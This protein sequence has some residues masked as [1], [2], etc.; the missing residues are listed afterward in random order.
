MTKNDNAFL[1]LAFIS[2]SL[3]LLLLLL[4]SLERRWLCHVSLLY[5]EVQAP[6]WLQG[7]RQPCLV[8][9]DHCDYRS[10]LCFPMC[11]LWLLRS[12]HFSII[13]TAWPPAHPL[14]HPKGQGACFESISPCCVFKLSGWTSITTMVNISFFLILCVLHREPTGRI[15]DV[16]I[17]EVE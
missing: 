15:F 13:K 10:G 1:G 9:A 4:V 14:T 2:Y 7:S 8:R 17:F 12:A 5:V 16:L 11:V 6:G 3:P